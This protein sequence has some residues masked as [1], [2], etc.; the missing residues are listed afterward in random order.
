[1]K[2]RFIICALSLLLTISCQAPS[3][4]SPTAL[5]ENGQGDYNCYRIPAILKAPDGS[6]LAFAEG[7]RKSCSDFGDVDLLMRRS[8]DG[9]KTWDSAKL[10][11]D[12]DTLQAGNPAP[13]VD[14]FDPEYP[15]GRVFLFYNTGNA[16]ENDVRNGK[17]TREVSYISSIDNGLSWSEPTEITSSVHFNRNTVQAEKDWRTNATTPGH[18]LQFKRGKYKGRIYIPANHSAGPP[19]EKFNEYRAYGFYSDDHGKT[20]TVSPDI[21]IPSSNEAIGVEL[22]N[23]NLMLNIREQNGDSKQRLVAISND[24]GATWDR[25]YFDA[26]LITP[27]CQSSILLFETEQRNFLIY[28][29][30]NSTSKREKMT[31]KV[32]LDSGATWTHKL[33]VHKGGAA[34]SDL[35]QIDK[36]HLGLFYEQDFKKMVFEVFTPED[37]LLE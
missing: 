26:E 37:L 16:S 35:V 1:M 15:Q 34:Y 9:G 23:G 20:W 31:L 24:G 19:Q 2:K 10:L 36:D 27:V 11:V 32:S 7:R 17:G 14:F 6:L 5:F 29:G 4:P 12:N 18:A 13:V 3:K 8:N 22:P 28:S 30:P 25:T 21:A 33:E